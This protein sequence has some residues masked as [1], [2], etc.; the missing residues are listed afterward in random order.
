MILIE[1]DVMNE[2]EI[3]NWESGRAS[4][5]NDEEFYQEILTVFLEENWNQKLNDLFTAQDWENYRISVHALKSNALNIGSAPLSE[6]AKANE[7]AVKEKRY[8]YV[9]EHHAELMDLLHQVESMV[10]EYLGMTD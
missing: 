8:D 2:N 1:V 7:M 4:C 9:R 5:V 3:I 6:K 10:K